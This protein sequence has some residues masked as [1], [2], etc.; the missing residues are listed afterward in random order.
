MGAQ[1]YEK[2][3][4]KRYYQQDKLNFQTTLFINLADYYEPEVHKLVLLYNH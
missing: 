3:A 4:E 2:E 1:R